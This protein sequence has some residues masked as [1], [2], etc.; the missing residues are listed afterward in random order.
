MKERIV[1]SLEAELDINKPTAGLQKT[2]GF[3]VVVRIAEHFK[4]PFEI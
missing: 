3:A 1:K 4:T 2:M